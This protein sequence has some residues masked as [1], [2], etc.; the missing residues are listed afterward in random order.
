MINPMYE[1]LAKLVVNYSVKVKEEDRVLISGPALSKQLFQAIYIEVLKAGGHPFINAQLE[2]INEILFKFGS[3]NQIR[4]MDGIIKQIYNEFNQIIEIRADYNTQKL[5][6]V[7]P[8][9]IAIMQGSE[10]RRE[11]VEIMEKRSSTGE[12][13]WV[14]V[15]FPC[16]ALAQDAE[17]DLFTYTDFVIKSLYLDK[18][19]PVNEWKKVKE[20]QDKLIE[21]LDKVES[22]HVLGEDTDLIMSLKGRTW[23]NC[24]GQRNLPDGEVFTGPVE[25]SVNGHIRFTFPG[26]YQGK[27]VKNIYLEFKDGKVVDFSAEK[28]ED[29]LK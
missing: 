27:E 24:C 23:R 15:P 11:V 25:N 2:G 8:Q 9:K 14:V 3:D 12:L 5:A 22:L 18:E 20:K 6:V 21:F 29:L 17:M 26:I 1:K 16:E 28:G 4:H 10:E 7:D 13:N 19:D